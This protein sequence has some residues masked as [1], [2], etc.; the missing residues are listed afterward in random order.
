MAN[1]HAEP[2]VIPALLVNDVAMSF[3]ARDEPIAREI[4]SKLEGH[5]KVF[6]FPNR[7]EEL[8]GT[9]GLESMRVPFMEARVVVVLFRA[10]WGDT[11]WT[12]V[13]ATAIS[14]RCLKRGWDSL[15]FITLDAS[16]TPI[17]LPEF[18]I[19]FDLESYGIE[20]AVGAIKARVQEKGGV[21]AKLSPIARAKRV[22]REIALKGDQDRFFRDQTWIQNTARLQIE[23]LI[24]ALVTEV[25]KIKAES[26]LPIE[27][28]GN[29]LRC[30]LRY[31]GCRSK[32]SGISRIR[33]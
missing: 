7:Q 31:G 19:R 11:N 28:A 13:E 27:A 4:A 17:W 8:A 2:G 24:S 1:A 32:S 15:L 29:K 21:L 12:R 9:N 14:E 18:H 16:P 30:I 6:F 23:Q 3:L 26:G 33:T 22:A 10:P 25:D 20:Q 5:L